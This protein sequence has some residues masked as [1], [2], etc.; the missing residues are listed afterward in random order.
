MTDRTCPLGADCDLTV[1]WMAGAEDVRRTY[2][3]RL[4]EAA[5]LEAQVQRAEV[6]ARLH[7]DMRFRLSAA[8]GNVLESTQRRV[9]ACRALADDMDD[10]DPQEAEIYRAEADMAEA[11]HK[12]M[13]AAFEAGRA[14]P[15]ERAVFLEHEAETGGMPTE[16]VAWA[17]GIV[18]EALLRA[19]GQSR[20]SIPLAAADVHETRWFGQALKLLEGMEAMR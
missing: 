8:L 15:D 7:D 1:A 17:A 2:R 16:V 11:I 12:Q 19:D 20:Y 5:A 10:V 9:W 4:D 13:G 14:L 6:R 3:A 18:R